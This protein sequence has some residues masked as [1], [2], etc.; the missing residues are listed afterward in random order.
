MT[1]Q[2]ASKQ[3]KRLSPQSG[4]TLIESV[5]V[6]GVFGVILAALWL[7]VG[8]VYENVRQYNASR[9]I[10][11]IV[12]NARQI[13]SA[14]ATLTSSTDYTARF[15]A[16]RVFPSEMLTSN[17]LTTA[18][19]NHPWETR[20]GGSVLV[21]ADTPAGGATTTTDFDV[22]FTN[23]PQKACISMLA[24]TSTSDFSGVT[25]VWLNGASLALPVTLIQA[26][27]NCQA[28]NANILTW[29][30]PMRPL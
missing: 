1:Y 5:I 8:V 15:V 16:Q 7:V 13:F 20:A 28:G 29:V 18:R 22:R 12:N 3:P 2:L 30:F 14:S 10:Q 26:D 23:L 19:P 4:L 25:Q 21:R 6:L 9:Q 11:T 17:D 24:K 27:T